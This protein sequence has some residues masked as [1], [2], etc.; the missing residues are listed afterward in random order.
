MGEAVCLATVF[1]PE[2]LFGD[3]S[4]VVACQ[5]LRGVDLRLFLMD[6]PVSVA[7]K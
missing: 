6:A 3:Q 4:S 5:C 1:G 7:R 2:F